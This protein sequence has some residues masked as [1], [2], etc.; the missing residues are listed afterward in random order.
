[1]MILKLVPAED[2]RVLGLTKT[3]LHAVI[4]S[5]LTFEAICNM[6]LVKIGQSSRAGM[7]ERVAVSAD[8]RH[9]ALEEG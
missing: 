6:E 5:R 2:K 4:T 8:F 7:L 1:M 9:H 3:L